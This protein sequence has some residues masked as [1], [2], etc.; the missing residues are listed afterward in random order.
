MG[1]TIAD[2]I[3]QEGKIE[4]KLETLFRMGR[5]KW[6]PPDPA[7]LQAMQSITDGERLDRMSDA[8]IDAK[9]WDDLVNIP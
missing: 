7:Q 2:A 3:S 8:I 5:K 1:M 4:G 6:G 9:S